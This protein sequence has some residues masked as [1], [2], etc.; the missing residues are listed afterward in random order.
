MLEQ[1]FN[2]V[3]RFNYSEKKKKEISL[4]NIRDTQFF[5]VSC[6]MHVLFQQGIFRIL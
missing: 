3:F 6:I 1:F 4:E 5:S 2:K